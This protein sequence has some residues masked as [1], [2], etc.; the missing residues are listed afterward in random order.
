M[1]SVY[2]RQ[3]GRWVAAVYINGKKVSKYGKTKAEA[4]AKLKEFLKADKV[5]QPET[6]PDSLSLSQWVTQWLK[7]REYDLRP[8]T[9]EGYRRAL[10]LIPAKVGKVP[11]D[12]L[13]PIQLAGF[14][15]SVKPSRL[16]QLCYTVLRRCLK[17]AVNMELLTRNPLDKVPKPVW[18]STRDRQY[19]TEDEYKRFLDMALN[20]LLDHVQLFAFLAVTG[21]RISEAL[22]LTQEDID[23]S[24]RQV[25]VNKALV[26]IR[27][28]KRFELMPTKTK[29]GKRRVSLPA[30]A[31][32]AL[33]ELPRDRQHVFYDSQPPT[34]WMLRNDLKRLCKLAGVPYVNLH[35]LR[36]I[37]ATTAIRACQD[38]HAVSRRL[39]HT[40]ISTTLSLYTYALVSDDAVADA[41]DK[42]IEG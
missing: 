42:L 28:E 20:C 35:G 27:Q 26:Y 21:L 39:G 16:L 19:W 8:S 33:S 31:V 25:T 1:A 36:H 22:A 38:W 30:V 9:L 11:I 15:T 37:A 32:Q 3:D 13:T 24:A 10:A 18:K 34:F 4:K 2:K 14:F 12:S 5:K 29:A 41:L 6:K 17:D 7:M 23:L 40:Q